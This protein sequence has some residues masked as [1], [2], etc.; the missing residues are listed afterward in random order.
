MTDAASGIPAESDDVERAADGHAAVESAEI[1]SGGHHLDHEAPAPPRGK[2]GRKTLLTVAKVVLLLAMVGFAGYAL[3]ANWDKVS[4]ALRQLEPWVAVVSVPPV[5]LAMA[6]AMQVWRSLLSDLGSPIPALAAARI[7]FI[8]QLGKYVP[9]SVWSIATQMELGREYKVPRRVG[10]AVG[11][12]ALVLT[13]AVGLPLAAVTLPFAAPDVLGRY[14][15]VML[16][17]PVLL[18][19]LHPAVLGPLLNFGFRLIRQPALPKLPSVRG[20]V[21]A[22]GWQALVSVCFGLHAWILLIGLGAPA[23]RAL[24]AAIGGYALG[25]AIGLLAIP[26]PAGAVVREAALTAAFAAVVTV[27]QAAVVAVLSRV[28]LTVVDL[29]LAFTFLAVARRKAKPT[30]H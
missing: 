27:P 12:L 6:C 17:A 25:Y 1:A 16:T 4:D 15:W 22:A 26:V 18:A 11:V 21:R 29:G 2:S 9:G 23:G 19:V 8:S 5:V 3:V 24:L 10:F 30:T 20:M 14:W 13:A 28:A 7:F